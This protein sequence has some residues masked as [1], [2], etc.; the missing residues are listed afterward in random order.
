MKL[1]LY[2][3]LAASVVLVAGSSAVAAPAFFSENF[4]SPTAIGAFVSTANLTSRDNS[5]NLQ[6]VAETGN[7]YLAWVPTVD[8][9]LLIAGSNTSTDYDFDLRWRMRTTNDPFNQTLQWTWLQN[10]A[11]STAISF[12]IGR[13]A[14]GVGF[15]GKVDTT[16]LTDFAVAGVASRD[17]WVWIRLQKVG[18]AIN[19]KGWTGTL[20]NEPASFN[21]TGTLTDY[22]SPFGGGLFSESGLRFKYQGGLKIDDLSNVPE[23]ITLSL[24][25]LGAL[26]LLRRR[27]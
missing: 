7:Q 17:D 21:E 23:P 15:G 13:T 24:L 27:R 19:V 10:A 25:G 1:S 26:S 18:N 16:G 6:V 22:L 4:E 12:Q 11:P 2:L 20:A 9:H 8:T 3:M 5:A 14:T